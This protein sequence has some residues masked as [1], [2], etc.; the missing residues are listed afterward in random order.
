MP[1]GGRWP[2][3]LKE[4]SRWPNRD[5]TRLSALQND[6][7]GFP[8]WQRGRE[9]IPWVSI[10]STHALVLADAAG[11]P[12]ASDTLTRAL[13]HLANIE[14]FFPVEYGDAVRNSLS[15]YALYVRGEAGDRDVTKATN[16]YSFIGDDL[17]LD[18]V[19]W[20]W[21]S[22]VDE[23]L[24]TEIER[25]F[26]NSTVETAGAAT[27]ATSYGEDAYVIAHS[28]RK[29][30]GI[31]LDAL[32]TEIPDSDLIIKVVAG[33]LGNQTRG[34]WN[35]AHENAFILL[36]LNRYFDSFESVTPDFVARVWLGDLYA[37]E[38]PFVGRTTDRAATLVPMDQLSAETDSN[39]IVQKDGDGRLYY[40]LGLRYAPDDLQLD[41]RD[42]GFV[43]D[44]VYEGV[45]D[46]ADV[47]RDRD[48]TWHIKSGASVRV[49][50][51]MV[52][53]AR[54]THVALIDPLPAGL[55]PVNPALA[56]STTTAPDESAGVQPYSWFWGWNWFEHQNLRDDRAEAFTSF[57]PGGTYEYSYVA[58]ATTPGD[59]IVPPARAEEVYAPEVFGR[60]SSASVIIE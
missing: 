59:F 9:S 21:P 29:T 27:F 11:Y 39:V 54:R 8:Y 49:R 14:D 24:R 53:D 58:R 55:E 48:G 33:L 32:I 56:V 43:V 20:L 37:A 2:A 31:I 60:S 57:L 6:N 5:I 46:P 13:E 12:V 38:H 50:V 25:R 26:V 42:E 23:D 19:A 45:D 44:R 18:A 4:K 16:L 30:D 34:R 40:R 28:D 36:A 1:D 51:T 10:Q 17:E 7:G 52:A 3:V 41:A 22:I 15:S 47:T 35:N